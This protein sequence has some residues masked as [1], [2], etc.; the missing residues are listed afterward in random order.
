MVR[1]ICVAALLLAFAGGAGAVSLGMFS[2]QGSPNALLSCHKAGDGWQ[3]SSFE[4]DGVDRTDVLQ[5]ASSCAAALHSVE[6]LGN[7]RSGLEVQEEEEVGPCRFLL[8]QSTASDRTQ[9]FVLA[10]ECGR[11]IFKF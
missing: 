3:L 4:V 9:G 6:M 1:S 7:R 11:P 8:P 5:D 2:N 10:L